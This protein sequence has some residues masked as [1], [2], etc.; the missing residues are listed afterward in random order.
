MATATDIINRACR[1]INILAGEE[2]LSAAEASDALQN[3]ND[4]LH[5]FGPMGIKYAHTTL[6]AGDTVN[7]PDEQ[8]RNIMLMLCADLADEYSVPLGP[9]TS[10]AIRQAK[11][12]LQAAYLVLPPAVPDRSLRVRRPG[13]YDFAR[14]Q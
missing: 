10:E 4:M 1:R 8:L 9:E 12:E 2:A 6:A 5:A 13:F 3:L 11:N 7:F 14:G